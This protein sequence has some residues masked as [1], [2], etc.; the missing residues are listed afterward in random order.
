MGEH[1]AARRLDFSAAELLNCRIDSQSVA[2]ICDPGDK[3]GSE[4]CRGT[5]ELCGLSI[6]GLQ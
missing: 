3:V 4:L 5:A 6:V 1:L 2:G